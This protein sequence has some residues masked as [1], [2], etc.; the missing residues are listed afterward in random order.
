MA[1]SPH[2]DRTKDAVTGGR[3]RGRR[4]R[5]MVPD[6]EFGSYYGRPVLNAPVWQSPDV[7]GYLFLGGL[8]GASSLLG[9]GAAVSHRRAL[10]QL[11]TAASAGAALASLGAL[12]HDLGRPERFLNMLRVFKPSSP[13]S[14]GSWLLSGYA[15]AAGI[16]A[17][18]A[19]RDRL[20]RLAVAKRVLRCYPRTARLAGG[21]ATAVAAVTGPA[22]AAYTAA[23][24]S[25]TAVP[26]WHDAYR[27]LPFVFIGSAA[28]AAGG[29]ALFAPRHETA[30]ARLLAILGAG[31]ELTATAGLR[32]RLGMVA[33][34]Y[35]RGRGGLC[36]RVSKALTLVGAVGAAVSG[37]SRS[38]GAMSGFALLAASAATRFG[39][40]HAG[41][42][43][44]KDPKYTVRP[45]RER[46][47]HR[48]T[49]SGIGSAGSE[50][51]TE[52]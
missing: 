51:D 24:L 31:C 1:R 20:T 29:L 39:V 50:E 16:A 37:R 14:V 40:F 25:D 17:L 18:W 11:T 19:Q 9:A 22:V 21:G 5:P 2:A 32:D 52:D 3:G 35:D 33:E 23:L 48:R 13:M 46:L 44:A 4:E 26:A 36:L 42:A 38:L 28:Q 6:A 43:S 8:A 15:P 45:Q 47:E 10:Q 30:P 34:P 49:A 12:V 7:P 41:M 27:E